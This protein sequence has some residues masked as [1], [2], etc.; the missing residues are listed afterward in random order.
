[1]LLIFSDLWTY[2]QL[3]QPAR[4][5]LEYTGTEYEDKFYRCGEGK[6][7]KE[8]NE[9]PSGCRML[10]AVQTPASQISLSLLRS[11]VFGKCFN[12]WSFIRLWVLIKIIFKKICWS[13]VCES[14][15][16]CPQ[17][18]CCYLNAQACVQYVTPFFPS[19]RQ[20]MTRAAGLTKNIHLEWNSPT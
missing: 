2:L 10:V 14:H 3:A 11:T 8:M 17:H 18:N 19:Q 13:G 9:N 12:P 5:L 15:L 4:L 20:T 1:M 6:A 7:M 16:A